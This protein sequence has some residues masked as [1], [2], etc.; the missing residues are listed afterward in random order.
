M[1][2]EAHVIYPMSEIEAY[3][4]ANLH[5]NTNGPLID[6]NE[7]GRV[8]NAEPVGALVTRRHWRPDCG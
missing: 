7:S 8:D 1:K 3:E 6:G 4:A 5:V 2:I